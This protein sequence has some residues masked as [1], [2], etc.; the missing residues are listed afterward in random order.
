MSVDVIHVVRG[1][2]KDT[3]RRFKLVRGQLKQLHEARGEDEFESVFAAIHNCVRAAHAW[4]FSSPS[5]VFD[6]EPI[7]R[8][9]AEPPQAEE[10]APT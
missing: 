9:F 2:C 4:R 6:V 5:V 8:P 3:G 1:K 10:E 7:R